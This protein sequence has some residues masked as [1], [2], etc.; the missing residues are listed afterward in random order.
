MIFLVFL[1]RNVIIY[2]YL[3]LLQSFLLFFCYYYYSYWAYYTPIF[4]IVITFQ[5]LFY[6]LLI[7]SLSTSS[8]SLLIAHLLFI[9]FCVLPKLMIINF[10]IFQGFIHVFPR[11]RDFRLSQLTA[12]VV[13]EFKSIKSSGIVNFYFLTLIDKS[14]G[15][16]M[17]LFCSLP[18][19]C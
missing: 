12:R 8:N 3:Y 18:V 15:A 6:Y 16:S 2:Y 19:E 17:F 7:R 4:N 9:L 1:L 14:L 10:S 5:C 11:C 13:E